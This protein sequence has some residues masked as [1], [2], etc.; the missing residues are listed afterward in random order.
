VSDESVTTGTE[1]GEVRVDEIEGLARS[2]R[3]LAVAE[4]AAAVERHGR[5]AMALSGGSAAE[6]LLPALVGAPIDLERLDLFWVD[7]RA[8][9]P[10]DAESN[11]RLARA[12]WLD[13]AAGHARLHR[14]CG[15]A[16]DL[17]R[18][19]REAGRE[20][21]EALDG[22][23]IDLALVGVGPDGHVASL[24]PGHAALEES[25]RSVVAIVDAPKP[26]AR[27]LTIT[28]GVFARVDLLVVA[29]FGEEKAATL[30]AAIHE[31]LSPLPIARAARAAKRVVWLLDAA[32]ASA[33]D[34]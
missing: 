22:G 23:E 12:V 15:E 14:L 13:H 21:D 30:A 24:F 1:A 4:L 19:A 7:E 20:L 31:P 29:A 16:S 9:P 3:E 25:R 5:S 2:Y 18:A 10:D 32:A 17:E 26:P 28:L 27:R 11:Y 33:L 8:V 6:R 34:A